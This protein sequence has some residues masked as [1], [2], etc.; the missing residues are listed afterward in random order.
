MGS[1]MNQEEKKI[2]RLEKWLKA[3]LAFKNRIFY[4]FLLLFPIAT[5][6]SVI[7][8]FIT[9][10]ELPG[11]FVGLLVVINLGISFSFARKMMADISVSTDINKTLQ[12]FSEQSY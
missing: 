1:F 3:P 11:A 7:I 6:L 9:D 5:I 8:Y 10:N 2:D 12:Q 4:Y